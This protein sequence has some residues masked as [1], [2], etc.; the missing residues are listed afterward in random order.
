MF[1]FTL[2]WRYIGK[3]SKSAALG[4]DN[5]DFGNLQAM[6]TFTENIAVDKVVPEGVCGKS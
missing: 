5:N 1:G 6:A 4:T 3:L 2:S